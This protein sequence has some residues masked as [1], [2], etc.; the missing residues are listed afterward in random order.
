MSEQSKQEQSIEK[1]LA[2]G[3]KQAEPLPAKMER[4]DYLELRNGGL[5]VENLRMQMTMLQQR[6]MATEMRQSALAAR[7][8]EKYSLG[9][10]DQIQED[11][12]IVRK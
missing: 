8:A 3:L 9:E 7:L 2:E 1:E 12:T 11:G 6:L 10:H 5:E 4:L